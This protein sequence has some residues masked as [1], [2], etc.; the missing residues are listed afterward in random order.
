M[1]CHF[2]NFYQTVHFHDYDYDYRWQRLLART[3][4]GYTQT[5]THICIQ[6]CRE[7]VCAIIKS[8]QGVA[9][10]RTLHE[11]NIFY[12]INTY[13]KHTCTVLEHI[14]HIYKYTRTACT[15]IYFMR[16]IAWRMPSRTICLA[17]ILWAITR[18]RYREG[19]WAHRLAQPNVMYKRTRY[20]VP[21]MDR[22]R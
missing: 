12:C 10:S 1:L 2:Y 17:P 6:K 7:Y 14:L 9:H 4:T 16:K 22:I 15:R 8:L 18:Y 20:Y 3:W 13:K 21:R 11:H 19:V 5:H